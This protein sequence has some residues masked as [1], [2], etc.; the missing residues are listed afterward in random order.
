MNSLKITVCLVIQSCLTLCDPV[1]YSPPGSS[2]PGDSPGKNTG[3]GCH[4]FLQGISPTQGSNP[5][6]QDCRWILYCLSHRKSP[7]G[8]LVTLN[9]CFALDINVEML[10][11]WLRYKCWDTKPL[12]TFFCLWVQAGLLSVLPGPFRLMVIVI[13]NYLFLIGV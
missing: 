2:C 6:L 8:K 11:P 12:W 4:A 5:G 13:F 3:M 10:S 1:D 9:N 7:V